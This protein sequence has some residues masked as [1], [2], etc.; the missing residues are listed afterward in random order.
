[1]ILRSQQLTLTI[2]IVQDVLRG[3]GVQGGGVATIYGYVVNASRTIPVNVGVFYEVLALLS[4]FV[5][6][7]FPG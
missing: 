6:S 2:V 5:L 4:A 3:D 7:I 1:M